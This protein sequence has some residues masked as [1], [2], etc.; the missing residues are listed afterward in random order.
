M[1][2]WIVSAALERMD[3]QDNELPRMGLSQMAEQAILAGA[4]RDLTYLEVRT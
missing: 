3:A 1:E 2:T 4:L